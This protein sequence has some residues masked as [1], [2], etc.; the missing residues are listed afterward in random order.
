MSDPDETSDITWNPLLEKYFASTGEKANC[1]SYLHK[2]SEELYS[3]RSVLVDLPCICLATLNGATSI[4]SSALFGDSEY[5]SVG[6]GAIALL[7][8]ILQTVGSYFGWARRAEAHK[9]SHLN[10]AKLYRFLK[11]EM[12]LPRE[13]RMKPKELL[14]SIKEQYDRLAEVSP[15]IPIPIINDFK[16]KFINNPKYENIS[17]PSETNGLEEIVIYDPKKDNEFIAR[18]ITPQATP[19]PLPQTLTIHTTDAS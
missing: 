1:Y 17:T 8:A 2:K 18:T 3:N 14:K 12:G 10:Y 4:G 9:I 19:L 16:N 7:T 6:I 15:L 11:I 5:A 13:S